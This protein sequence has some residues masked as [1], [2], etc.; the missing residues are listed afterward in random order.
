MNIGDRVRLLHSSEE[1]VIS[2][3]LNHNLIEVEIEDGFHIPVNTT[4]IVLISREEAIQFGNQSII[5]EDS[6]STYK[7]STDTNKAFAHKG[8]FVAFTPINDRQYSMHLINNTDY[9]LPFLVCK[10]QNKTQEGLNGGAL[11]PKDSVKIT[12]VNIQ[13]FENWGVYVFQFLFFSLNNLMDPLVKRMRFRAQAFF[14]NK[15]KAPVI[16]KEAHLFQ[17]DSDTTLQ[18]SAMAS[19][20]DEAPPKIDPEKIKEQMFE[21]SDKASPKEKKVAV[22][23]PKLEVDLHI[24][25]LCDDYDTMNSGEI[26]EKQLQV[27]EA[28]LESAIASGMYEITFIHGV[29]NGRLRKEIHR[30]LSGNTDIK[31]FKDAHKEK[32]GYGATQV[33]FKD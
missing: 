1:G 7:P 20:A 23:A 2:K 15:H 3:I 29:G 5:Q 19:Y 16:E 10:E 27:F 31:Y 11:N 8:I 21:N 14:K 33:R 17:L 26:L 24:E 30:R 32:F 22:A 9:K 6:F 18:A 12:E 25:E 28:N 4:E 13:N